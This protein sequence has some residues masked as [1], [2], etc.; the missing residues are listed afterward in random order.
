M[1]IHSDHYVYALGYYHGRKDGIAY[2]E[3]MQLTEEEKAEYLKGYQ[4]GMED[5]IDLGYDIV[6]DYVE[7]PVVL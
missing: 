2:D 7:E 3:N 5:Y 1:S 4:R 6:P